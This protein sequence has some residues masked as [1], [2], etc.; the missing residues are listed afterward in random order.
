MLAG[1]LTSL[2][3]DSS[4][5]LTP[6]DAAVRQ[7]GMRFVRAVL[8]LAALAATPARADL[9]GYVK[10]AEPAARVEVID[11]RTEKGL[12]VTTLELVSQAWR[13]KPWRHELR[14]F[15]PM[16]SEPGDVALLAVSGSEALG[17][18]LAQRT[19]RSVATLTDVPNQPLYFGKREDDLLAHTFAE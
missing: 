10:R 15:R 16:P 5:P 1:T 11:E 19:G 8:V 12:A 13:G 18:A 3:V 14:V 9:A 2:M 17:R 4:S 6:A 7:S